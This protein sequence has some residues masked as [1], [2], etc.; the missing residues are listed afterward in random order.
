MRALNDALSALK[1][2]L[3]LQERLE[4]VRR[5]IEGLSGNVRR[6]EDSLTGLDRRVIR[7]ETMIEMA[8]GRPDRPPRLDG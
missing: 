8:Q 4:A 6:V 5:E 3:L 1:N 7:I 2:A